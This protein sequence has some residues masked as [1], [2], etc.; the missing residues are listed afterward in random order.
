M[1][2]LFPNVRVLGE[3]AVNIDHLPDVSKMVTNTKL[4]LN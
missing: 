1:S 3:E 4:T 2:K